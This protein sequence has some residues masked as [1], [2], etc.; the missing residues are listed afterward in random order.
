MSIPFVIVSKNKDITN[1]RYI[2]CKEYVKN[3]LFKYKIKLSTQ[4]FYWV[5]SK[6]LKKII[7]KMC[8]LCWF[9]F[10]TCVCVCVCVCE[11]ESFEDEFWMKIMII[12][13]ISLSLDHH[14]PRWVSRWRASA[15]L[16]CSSC[17]QLIII[18]IIIVII[19]ITITIQMVIM[20]TI[21]I[22]IVIIIIVVIW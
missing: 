11:K 14:G 4:K 5:Q 19:I 18:I 21:I 20:I 8:I 13:M 12:S 7:I 10:K 22:I 16:Y 9:K 3:V 15:G 2:L 6:I 1:K 17:M